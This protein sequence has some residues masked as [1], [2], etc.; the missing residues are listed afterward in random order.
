MPVCNSDN[1][2]KEVMNLRGMG[3]MERAREREGLPEAGWREERR[4]LM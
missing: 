2:E 4:K 3:N 1:Q